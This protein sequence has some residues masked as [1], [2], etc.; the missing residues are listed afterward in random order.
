MGEKKKQHPS[1]GR[2][3]LLQSVPLKN[4]YCLN[5]FQQVTDYTVMTKKNNKGNDI[6]ATS[7]LGKS[8]TLKLQ[9]WN[10]K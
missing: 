9:L 8:R 3:I 6:I 5:N 10:S 2:I 4:M 7:F 1:I